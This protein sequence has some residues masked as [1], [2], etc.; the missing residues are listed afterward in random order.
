MTVANQAPPPP[1]APPPVLQI[2][3]TGVRM[4]AEQG[5]DVLR[6]LGIEID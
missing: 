2:D 3:L 4:H 6:T 1:V 5:L